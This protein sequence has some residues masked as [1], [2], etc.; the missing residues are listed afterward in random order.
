MGVHHTVSPTSTPGRGPKRGELE[1]IP[2]VRD[3]TMVTKR[4]VDVSKAIQQRTGKTFH[5]ATRALPKRVRRPTYV[6]YAFFRIADEVVDDPSDA[7][8]SEQRDRLVAIRDAALG[9]R[10]TDEPVLVAFDDVRRRYGI[11]DEDVEAF[12]DAMLADVDKDQYA[13]YE[14]L[15]GYMHGSAA[16]VGTMMT[17]V[18]GTENIGSARPHAIALG[19]AFQ[20]TNFLRDV[21]EDIVDRDRIYL[22]KT[23]LDACGVDEA[24]VRA[25][26]PTDRFAEAMKR[27]LD[28][29]ETLYWKGVAGIEYLPADCQFPV[30]L[31]AVLYADHHRLIRANDYDT[32]TDT[33]ELSLR[34][35]LSLAARTRWYWAF[36]KN[37]ERVFAKA[38]AIEPLPHRH[39]DDA[40][41]DHPRPHLSP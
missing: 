3:I 17:A 30:L 8:P 27:E 9:R 40:D 41:T 39:T 10:E 23:T 32:L 36:D 4:Q 12:I 5:L 37:P 25:R 11:P 26:R 15:E 16:V 24:D 1:T 34:R 18:M 14:E 7:T 38:S 31:A 2:E 6:L 19:E 13:T 20:L 28:R 29:A 35:K 33:P 22:P 21:G